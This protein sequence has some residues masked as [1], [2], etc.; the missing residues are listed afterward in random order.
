MN[1][2]FTIEKIYDSTFAISEYKHW[3]QVHSYLLIGENTALLIDTGLGIENIK[4]EVD[5]LTNL[6]LATLF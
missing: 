2:W 3:E 4:N 5:K 1:D 6:D